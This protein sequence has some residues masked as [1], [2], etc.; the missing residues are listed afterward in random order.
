EGYASLARSVIGRVD[1]ARLL[2]RDG[3]CADATEGCRRAF[4]A[5]TGRRIFRRPLTAEQVARFTPLFDAVAKEGDPFPAAVALVVSAMLQSPEFLYRLES[6]PVDDFALAT[7]LAFL[8]WNSAPD[9][10]LLDA[11]ARSPLAGQIGRAS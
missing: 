11:A 9:D 3:V 6:G 5:V 8:L 10:A 1:W 2:A 7:R 4:F